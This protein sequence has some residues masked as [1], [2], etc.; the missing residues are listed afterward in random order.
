MVCAAFFESKE[1][2]SMNMLKKIYIYETPNKSS[3]KMHVCEAYVFTILLLAY[4][5][6]HI[7]KMHFSNWASTSGTFFLKK[8]SQ[9]LQFGCVGKLKW[10]RGPFEDQGDPIFG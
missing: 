2:E 7:T 6:V 1:H 8:L 9:G 10:A 3:T 4:G 5:K